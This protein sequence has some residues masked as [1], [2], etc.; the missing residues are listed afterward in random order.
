MDTYRERTGRR[1]FTEKRRVGSC[2]DERAVLQ[3]A[4]QLFVS[5]TNANERSNC[6]SCKRSHRKKSISRVRY[7]GRHEKRRSRGV[8]VRAFYLLSEFTACPGGYDL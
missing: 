2:S 3:A 5:V 7:R 8:S 4:R 6:C 1:Y